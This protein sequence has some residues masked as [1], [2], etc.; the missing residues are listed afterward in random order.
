MYYP[1]NSKK[2][3]AHIQRGVTGISPR[4]VGSAKAVSI[5]KRIKILLKDKKFIKLFFAVVALF[6]LLLLFSA[7]LVFTLWFAY[8][9]E[10]NKL[11]GFSEGLSVA[12]MTFVF[13]YGFTGF[14]RYTFLGTVKVIKYIIKGGGK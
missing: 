14:F 11:E 2:N 7:F 10:F 12:F 13:F 4:C 1:N 3:H 8:D 9:S 6:L 5:M